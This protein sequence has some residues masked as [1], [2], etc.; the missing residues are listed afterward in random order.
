MVLVPRRILNELFIE[1]WTHKKNKMKALCMLFHHISLS[2]T[3]FSLL[4]E[5]KADV[6][7]KELALWVQFGSLL[8]SLKIFATISRGSQAENRPLDT[9]EPCALRES[10]LSQ[11]SK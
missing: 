5:K 4:K 2:D 10:V 6:K 3:A 9:P 11:M 8:K 7:P 1:T